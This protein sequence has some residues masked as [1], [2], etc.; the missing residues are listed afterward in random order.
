VGA[1]VGVRGVP[2]AA[3]LALA[4]AGCAA[5]SA[6]SAP[7]ETVSG[8]FRLV[9]VEG[10]LEPLER[11]AGAPAGGA[12]AECPAAGS[13]RVSLDARN[14]FELDVRQRSPCAAE[15]RRELQGTYFRR[16]EHLMF[17]ATLPGGATVRFQ[18][19]TNDTVVA[20]RLTGAELVFARGGAAPEPSAPP[21]RG[22]T[23]ER[24][25]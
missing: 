5:G 4:G 2:L 16:G 18:G 24:T 23:S 3:L 10:R 21:P 25:S 19:T 17:V 15:V 20:V 12:A 7:P 11:E 8:S 1:K 9:R 22:G 13:G 14:Q 6:G